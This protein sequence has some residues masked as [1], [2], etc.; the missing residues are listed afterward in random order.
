MKIR[1]MI[2]QHRRDFIAIFECEHC[3]ATERRS[4]YDDS[5]FHQHVIPEMECKQCGKSAPADYQ[6]AATKYPDGVQV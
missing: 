5:Y 2:S 1:K 6:A 3:K 4:G